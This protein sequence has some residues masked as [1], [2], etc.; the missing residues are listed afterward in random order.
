LGVIGALGLTPLDAGATGGD[1]T[2]TTVTSSGTPSTFGQS[3]TFTATVTGA[4]TSSTVYGQGGSFTS[5]TGNNGGVSA[6]SLAGPHNTVEDAA[7]NL[8]VADEGNSQVLYYPKGSTTATAVYGQGGSFTS[9]TA[10]NGGRSAAS[11]SYP[12]GLALD[13]A[14]NLYVADSGNNRVLF[15]PAGTGCTAPNT[16]AGCGTAT[17]IWGDGGAFTVDTSGTTDALLSYPLGVGVDPSGNL[18]V[19]EHDNSRV[20]YFPAGSGCTG[21]NTPSGCGVATQVYG[22]GGSFTSDT[23]NNGG[24]SASSLYDPEGMGL[25][26]NG[27]LYVADADNNRVLYFPGGSGCTAPS[28]PAGCATATRVYG[29]AGSFTSD[30]VNNGGISADSLWHPASVAV[31]GAG[32]VYVTDG[33]NNR[34]LYYPAGVTTALAVYGQGGSF[35]SGTANN[36]GVSA[37]SLSYP[38]GVSVDAFGNVYI[39][40]HQ[41]N[42]V[43]MYPAPTGTVTFMDGATTL[44]TGTLSD[45][46]ATYTTSTL[47]VG[48][49]AITAVYN[50]G[51][52]LLGS[53]SAVF[54]QVVNAA[55]TPT[56]TPTAASTAPVP[57]A[58]ATGGQ[59]DAGLMTVGW[60]LLA[61][62]L[63]LLLV[64][65]L[66]LPVGVYRRRR[67]T[68]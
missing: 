48:S 58:G 17:K 37:A 51:A 14:G 1:A 22:Q 26:S 2:T 27:N 9:G 46:T 30:T 31:D 33:R 18:Y 64:G 6:T 52:L 8:Y 50:G 47:A 59:R 13:A 41:N 63:L 45:G 24:T 53:T 40:D 20:L 56:P 49:H 60:T 67:L 25:D 38:H 44:G 11:L 61:G 43:L 32:N 19:A 7:G 54:T 65:G 4:S 55:P 16:P 62:G 36:G 57:S 34:A 29:Q 42:R 15:F 12:H 35:T 39:A 10:N 5:N 28:T 68:P 66:L 3:V 21:P 23:A